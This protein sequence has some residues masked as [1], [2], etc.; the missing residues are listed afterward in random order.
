LPAVFLRFLPENK[1]EIAMNMTMSSHS[2]HRLEIAG[3]IVKNSL[4]L[5]EKQ[6]KAV[7]VCSSAARGDADAHSDIDLHLVYREPGSSF[8]MYATL[9]EGIAVDWVWEPLEDYSRVEEILSHYAKPH[10]L[11]HAVIL[12]DPEGWLNRLKQQVVPQLER[13]DCV[14]QRLARLWNQKHTSFQRVMQTEG[15]E[16]FVPAYMEDFRIGC[17]LPLA[18]CTVDPSARKLLFQAGRSLEKLGAEAGDSLHGELPQLEAPML[19]HLLGCHDFTKSEAE[20]FLARMMEVYDYCIGVQKADY[21]G[22]NQPKRS[23]HSG[24]IRHWIGEG[25]H[26]EAMYPIMDW[27]WVAEY[28]ITKESGCTGWWTAYKEELFQRLGL[29]PEGMEAKKEQLKAVHHMLRQVCGG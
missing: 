14:A 21:H 29:T 9:E 1:E 18:A 15:F 26:R 28:R 24:G 12:Y 11:A 2:L 7:Y 20:Y 10:N 16:A 27:M 25:Y 23:C 19:L 17:L 8:K 22:I 5:F 13:R 4:H 3:R 6:V